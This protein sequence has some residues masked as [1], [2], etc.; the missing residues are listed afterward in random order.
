MGLQLGEKRLNVMP[1]LVAVLIL[2]GAGFVGFNLTK[3]TLA[4]FYWKQS[5]LAATKDKAVETYQLQI[6]T[7]GFNPN[8][9]DYRMIY[10]QT[11]LALASSLL[12]KKDLTDDEKQQASTLVQ[13]SVREAKAAISLNGNI[14]DYWANL[15]VI[16]KS[17]IGMVDGSADWSVQAYQ[18]AILLN[19]SSVS[20][21]MDLGGLYYAGGD[22]DSA[23][24]YFERSIS[25]K[26]DYANS[27][28]NWAYSAKQ[29]KKLQAAVDRM[30]QALKFVPAD[31]ADYQK[32][33]E[34]LVTWKKELD[35]ATKQQAAAQAQQQQ[36]QQ[37]VQPETLKT[38]E[39]LPT[40]TEGNKVAVPSGTGEMAPPPMVTPTAIVTPGQ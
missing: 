23:D 32:A 12:S 21:N 3:I 6:K 36:N 8:M 11:N 20:L 29:T 19:P 14:S 35:E 40:I 25:N 18:Q 34:E 28:Y 39:A 1:Y 13:Q 24:R 27:W 4:D 5:V 9:A 33:S 30:T 7:I 10:S 26:N 2:A 38:P 16:Y 37:Q 31:S 17:L 22:F 15:A